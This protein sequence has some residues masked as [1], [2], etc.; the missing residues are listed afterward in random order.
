MAPEDQRGANR[1]RP[2]RGREPG[3]TRAV[4]GARRPV[5][6]TPSG[7]HRCSVHLPPPVRKGRY[8][9]A[10]VTSILRQRGNCRAMI[11]RVQP[12]CS[13]HCHQILGGVALRKGDLETA[14]EPLPVR[15]AI[16][17]IAFERFVPQAALAKE[18]LERGEKRSSCNALSRVA[19]TGG[20]N[21]SLIPG[22]RLFEGRDAEFSANRR[23][24]F[25][26]RKSILTTS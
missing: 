22:S 14:S 23:I 7:T 4:A 9:S 6:R 12:S 5:R 18:L 3:E 16:G 20:R 19:G 2:H 25:W 1:R 10:H 21:G 17:L 26:C 24:E 13:S 8:W 11:P 15:T